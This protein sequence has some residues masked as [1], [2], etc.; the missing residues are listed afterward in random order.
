MMR[1]P[2]AHATHPDWNMA[3]G[4]VVAQLK[5]ALAGVSSPPPLGLV[6]LTDHFAAQAEALLAGL[7]QAVPSVSSWSGAVSI[8]VLADEAEYL[9]EPA[10]AV[11]LLDLPESEFCVFSGIAPLPSHFDAH[12]ALVHADADMT[13]LG[14]NVRELASRMVS[15]SVFGA[16]STTRSRVVQV[17]HQPGQD[18]EESV[19]EGGLS[20]VAFTHRIGVQMRLIHGC[21]PIGRER[22]LTEAEGNLLLALDGEPALDQMLG[23][24]NVSLDQPRQALHAVRD[25]LLAING[26]PEAERRYAGQLP[27][28]AHVRSVVGVD[29]SRSGLAL[30]EAVDEGATVTFCQR[31]RAFARADLTRVCTALRESLEPEALDAVQAQRLLAQAEAPDRES[32]WLHA[33]LE[34]ERIAGAVYM[35]CVSRGG[36]YFGAPGAELQLL[37]HALGRVPVVGLMAGGE[38]AHDAVHGFSGVLTVFLRED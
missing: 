18:A 3:L 10:L 12:T 27:A 32:R 25:T 35:S 37:R 26:R 13:E 38:I 20:G 9:D 29:P 1:F 31:D 16:L 4:L 7:R 17:A 34:S 22:V 36:G 21:K 30:A 15:G 8:G 14:E 11:M 28:K 19:L 24:L 33:G 23:D 2:V 6:Y 5:A